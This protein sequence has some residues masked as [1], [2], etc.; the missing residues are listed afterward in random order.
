MINSIIFINDYSIKR[1]K[2]ES[3]Q[4]ISSTIMSLNSITKLFYSGDE[5]NP[6]QYAPMYELDWICIRSVLRQ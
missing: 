4:Q 5:N 2:L 3:K 6:R 1:L